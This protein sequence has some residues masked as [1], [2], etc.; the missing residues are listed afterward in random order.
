MVN[1]LVFL[2]AFAPRFICPSCLMR[3]TG[4]EDS[5]VAHELNY[6]II[7]G[8]TEAT[9]ARCASCHRAGTVVR[10]KSSPAPT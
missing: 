2:Q 6:Q 10:F 1:V 7:V 5:H 8:M 9:D 3:V 4:Q